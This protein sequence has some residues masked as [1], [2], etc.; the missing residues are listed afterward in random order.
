MCPTG[1]RGYATRR[2][3]RAMRRHHPGSS[4]RAYKCPACGHWHLG[5]L[6]QSTKHGEG[7]ST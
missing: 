1:K 4:R 3:A 5:R 7:G 2:E 6:T